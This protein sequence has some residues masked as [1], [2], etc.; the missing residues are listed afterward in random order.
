MAGTKQDTCEEGPLLTSQPP[1]VLDVVGIGEQRVEW[2]KRDCVYVLP[3]G[4][5]NTEISTRYF[6]GD[7]G[8][9]DPMGGI[10]KHMRTKRGSTH[11]PAQFLAA[12]EKTRRC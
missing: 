11:M 1:V 2:K 12:Q 6:W 7:Y 5:R 8:Y 9:V 10:E 4:Y 3:A